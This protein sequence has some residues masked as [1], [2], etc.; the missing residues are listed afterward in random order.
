MTRPHATRTLALNGLTITAT[1]SSEDDALLKRCCRD[2]EQRRTE[3]DLK[4]KQR[5]EYYDS[6]NREKT[7]EN[8]KNSLDLLYEK[9]R[10]IGKSLSTDFQGTVSREKCPRK[11]ESSLDRIVPASEY[12]PFERPNGIPRS[13]SDIP[14]IN[15][16]KIRQWCESDFYRTTSR[17]SR[18]DKCMTFV[19]IKEKKFADDSYQVIGEFH[20]VT[21]EV[22]SGRTCKSNDK[23]KSFRNGRSRS[24]TIPRKWSEHSL[25]TPSTTSGKAER[26]HALPAIIRPGRGGNGGKSESVIKTLSRDRSGL[27]LN[28][29]VGNENPFS[30]FSDSDVSA[31]FPKRNK[32]NLIK[33]QNAI[34]SLF[35]CLSKGFR[36]YYR[37][38]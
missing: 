38:A 21:V 17:V 14:E 7:I 15:K 31:D 35:L 32:N 19:P 6:K 26:E 33:F 1:I 34:C 37:Y 27:V 3:Y 28:F 5:Q 8:S 20:Q 30:R 18:R 25:S 4:C 2:E 16:N 29:F 13:V 12:E 23:D 10:G 24:A 22:E 9:K 11:R 36:R